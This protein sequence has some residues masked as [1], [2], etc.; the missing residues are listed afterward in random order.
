MAQNSLNLA[1][2]RAQ[3]TSF[4]RLLIAVSVAAGAVLGC[5]APGAPVAR[6]PFVPKAITDLSAKQSGDSIVLS[7]TLPKQ[8]VQGHVLSKPPAIEIYRAFPRIEEASGNS[9]LTQPQLVATIPPQMVDQYRDG[10][11]ILFRDVLAS[12]DFAAHANGDAVY[13]VRMRLAKH[14][15]AASNTV[16]I[17][18]LPAAQRIEN[19]HAVVSKAAIQLTWS[20][21]A[22]SPTGSVAPLS[23]RYNV[24]RADIP[25]GNQS[26]SSENA[27]MQSK[28][29]SFVLLAELAATSCTDANFTFGHTYAYFVRT[30]AT[31]PSG[32]VESDES[33][34][35]NVTPR[36]TFAPA[37]PENL[38]ATATVG[39]GPTVSHVDLSWAISSEADL[40]GYNVYRSEMQDEIGSRINSTPL[41]TPAYRDDSVTP[42]TRYF[43]RVTAIDRAGNES[44]P[45]N[46]I[47]VNLQQP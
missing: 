16:Q 29:A 7:F 39:N 4:S 5:A 6:Q 41:I 9:G 3:R 25:P 8:T 17:H 14:D 38:T 44:S 33:T 20:A 28:S 13:V 15:S 40:L 47:M 22:I 30:V 24:Y 35:L 21:P 37:T 11:H 12:E 2:V 19:L 10:D 36:D 26:L 23:L 18:I 43:Y 34:I 1:R 45:S 32:S 42:G 27:N 31:Y 46:P